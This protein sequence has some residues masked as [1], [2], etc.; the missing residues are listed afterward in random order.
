MA[1]VLALI[2][3]GIIVGLL[4][5]ELFMPSPT[6]PPI[7][8]TAFSD[9][10]PGLGVSREKLLS[11]LRETYRF[12]EGEK[13]DD[14]IVLRMAE[15]VA[16]TLHGPADNVRTVIIDGPLDQ[17]EL[18]DLARAITRVCEHIWKDAKWLPAW[19][20][21][22]LQKAGDDFIV[23]TVRDDIEV[24]VTFDNFD[25]PRVAVLKIKRYVK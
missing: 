4:A 16:I 12:T 23:S 24:S 7:I 6:P 5:H 15:N 13:T 2:S 25:G 8:P 19:Y 22:A 18:V 3:L 10:R 14:V 17:L 11:T 20:V 21:A 9:G 1:I